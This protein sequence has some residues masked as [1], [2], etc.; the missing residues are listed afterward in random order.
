MSASVLHNPPRYIPHPSVVPENGCVCIIGMAGA[1]K[2]TVG[3]EL[4]ALLGWPQLDTDHVI[5]ATYG[6]RLQAIAD[7]MNKEEFLDLEGAV[8]C[9]L[10]VQ[11]CVVSTGGSAAYRSHAIRHLK[12]LGPMIHL[13]VPLPVILERIARKPERGL[14]IN[15]GQTVEDLFHEREVLYEEAADFTVYGGTGPAAH[16]AEEIAR[17]L[18]APR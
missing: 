1:G 3:R 2:T 8:L 13:S 7:S 17:L 12:T 14:A 4:A 16:Y 18:A 15:P 11:R 5:E 10:K 6:A 9:R